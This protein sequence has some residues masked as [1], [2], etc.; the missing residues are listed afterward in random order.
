L[1]YLIIA[2]GVFILDQISKIYIIKTME[3]GNSIPVIENIFHITYVKNPGAAFGILQHQTGLFIAIAVL[4]LA[5]VL[6]FYPRLPQGYPLIRVAIGL[7]AGG[8]VGNLLDRVRT[9][10]V[11]DFFDFRVWP[12]FNVADMAIVVGVGL[13]FLEIVRMP[14][15]DK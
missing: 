2:L 3:V 11:T 5:A 4:L 6:Y 7:Q 10:Y 14:E 8:A 13:L 1:Q 15:E 9:G 12:V